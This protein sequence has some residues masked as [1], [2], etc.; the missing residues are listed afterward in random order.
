ML[1]KE[2]L[3]EIIEKQNHSQNAPDDVF[4]KLLSSHCLHKILSQ[5][6]PY[7]DSDDGVSDAYVTECM[8]IAIDMYRRLDFGSELLIVYEDCYSENNKEEIRF[9]ESCLK[10]VSNTEA[11]SF[12]WK[13]RP[14]KETYP[15][16]LA[17]NSDVHTCTR[18]LY[19]AKGIIIQ[20]LFLEIILSDIGGKY[21]LDSK[22]FVIDTTSG[23]MFHLYDDRG[24]WVSGPEGINFPQPG[25]SAYAENTDGE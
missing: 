22:I 24:L 2:K 21:G 23:C 19:E 25:C 15:A 16:A 20:R 4:F 10:G 11:Y 18:R 17:N 12:S 9:V 1:L 3:Q 14:M 7:L 6:S 13:F 5:G 8:D